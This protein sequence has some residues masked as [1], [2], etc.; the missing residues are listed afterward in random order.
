MQHQAAQQLKELVENHSKVKLETFSEWLQQVETGL[1]HLHPEAPAYQ[2][3]VKRI[4]AQEAAISALTSEQWQAQERAHLKSQVDAICGIVNAAINEYEVYGAD[5]TSS[6][7][8]RTESDAVYDSVVGLIQN[9]TI[10]QDYKNVVISDLRESQG[11]YSSN[12]FKSAVV[13]L[14]AALE[15][16]MLGTL[17]R[18]DVIV[19]IATSTS[20]PGPIQGI[21]TGDPQLAEKIGKDLSFEDYKVCIHQLI[22][23][24]DALG[25]DNIQEFRNAI[26]PWKSIKEPAKYG[27]FDKPRALHYLGSIQKIAETVCGWSP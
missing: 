16:L 14:G 7:V 9:C 3:K 26:H 2:E 6:A 23:G 19:H 11:A 24:S 15:G 25:V 18:T 4:A 10:P 12:A 17:Q 1:R 8:D 21:G 13:M 22:T 20:P 27:K 5:A